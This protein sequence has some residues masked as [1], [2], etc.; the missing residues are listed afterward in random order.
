MSTVT[1]TSGLGLSVAAGV[2]VLSVLVLVAAGAGAGY[3]VAGVGWAGLVLGGSA[4]AGIF[5]VVCCF[6]TFKHRLARLIAV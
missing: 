3:V 1:A 2:T 5:S 6:G 4:P